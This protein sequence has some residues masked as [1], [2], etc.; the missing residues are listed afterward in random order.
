VLMLFT[1]T[2]GLNALDLIPD[3]FYQHLITHKYKSN[4]DESNITR[5]QQR[6]S[7][8]LSVRQHL[9]AGRA[10]T[11]SVLIPWLE[12]DL[13]EIIVGKL[14]NKLLLKNT[15]DNT[16]YTDDII[17]DLLNGLNNINDGLMEQSS[18]ENFHNHQAP[19]ESKLIENNTHKNFESQDSLI[20]RN[21]ETGNDDQLQG[22]TQTT[23]FSPDELSN[24]LNSTIED[25]D[26]AMEDLNKRFKLARYVGWDLL[27]GIESILDKQLLIQ[28]HQMIKNSRQIKTIIKMIGSKQFSKCELYEMPGMN[29]Q[30]IHINGNALPDEHSINSV[31]GVCYG[32]NLSSVLP[33]EMALMANKNLK[34]LWYSRYVERKLLS[35]HFKG[36]MSDHVPDVS[37]KSINPNMKGNNPLKNSGPIILCIDT[38]ASMKGRPECLAKAIAL[39]TMRIAH[40]EKRN[41]YLFC[42]SGPDEI[43]QLELDVSQGWKSII[44]FL[45]LSFHGG[46]DINSVMYQAL[47]LHNNK[48]WEKADIL[49]LSDGRFEMEST[50]ID[51]AKKSHPTLSIFGI[52]LGQWN[53]KAFNQIC[54][55]V[56]DLSNA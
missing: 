50:M 53:L 20:T 42:F 3:R 31:T 55:Q 44:D 16:S 11:Q 33:L 39:E 29:Q 32:N 9:L 45:R 1:N 49:L 41:C 8:V 51:E 10:I 56:F 43:I 25:M 40:N 13:A 38:S 36:I 28:T 14:D 47:S 54:H 35:Y 26:V 23:Q 15:F 19:D 30:T 4:H 46:T 7:S 24:V 18:I 2:R 12:N 37:S 48:K 27:K 17:L 21:N 5:L 52:Q 6:V 34:Y 22:E